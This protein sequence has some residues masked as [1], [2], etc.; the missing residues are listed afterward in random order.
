MAFAPT[1]DAT[2]RVAR[3]NVPYVIIAA[4]YGVVLAASWQT[5][6]LALMMPGS[7]AEGLK[8]EGAGWAP[9]G[10]EAPARRV[11]IGLA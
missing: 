1:A 11:P 8:G 9:W 5:D 3:S 4:A 2:R 6:T 10:V 7:L